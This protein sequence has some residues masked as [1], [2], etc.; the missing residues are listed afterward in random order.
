MR[1]WT[2]ARSSR[3]PN[4]ARVAILGSEQRRITERVRA[5]LAEREPPGWVP[6]G[7]AAA[8]S[9]ASPSPSPLARSRGRERPGPVARLEQPGRFRIDP[10]RRT[11]VL[12]AVVAILVGLVAGGWVLLGR[13]HSQDVVAAT[14]PASSSGRAAAVT[15]SAPAGSSPAAASPTAALLVVDVVGKVAHPGIYRVPTG[16]RVD[17]VLRA[18]G[19]ALPGVDLTVLNLARRIS[20]GEQV[21]VGISTPAAAGGAGAGGAAA[22]AGP[23]DLNGAT[24]EQLDALP[25]VGP[26]L[27]QHILDWRSAHGRFGSVNDLRQV[28]GI[29]D[30]KF[31]D[32]KALVT[33]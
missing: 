29:G 31:Q 18:A 27:A 12:V 7:S 3:L 25:G 26:V 5:L 30:S 1:L 19:G 10:G 17:D 20:D 16:S 24:L 32:L 21:A 23:L 9:D 8:Q 15:A 28:S 33:V 2:A 4:V 22:Q 6:S 14:V 11:A 13:A